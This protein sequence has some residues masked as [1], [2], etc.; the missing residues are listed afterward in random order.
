MKKTCT[1]CS[2]TKDV[3]EFHK[4][5]R[6]ADGYQYD[7][8]ACRCKYMKKMYQDN[9]EYREKN[10]KYALER[11]HKVW[12]SDPEH[13]KKHSDLVNKRI[14]EQYKESPEYRLIHNTRSRVHGVLKSNKSKST[15][16]YIGCDTQTLKLHLEQ[17]F[18][19]GMTWDNYGEWHVDH[20]IPLASAN[21]MDELIP[22]LHHT[23]LQPLWAHDNLVKSSTH[24][25]I[26]HGKNN[27]QK[28]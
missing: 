1:K 27:T 8:K 3:S 18:T 13:R 2:E 9:D 23:N 19:E 7:C 5:K 22:L 11:H 28:G 25:G 16:D 14:K 15:I 26:R 12:G 21:N 10:K 4:N 24:N 17:Q 6:S 20:I